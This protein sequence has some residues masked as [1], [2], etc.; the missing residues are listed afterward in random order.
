ML[1]SG[2][3]EFAWQAQKVVAGRS[4]CFAE[5]PGACMSRQIFRLNH[6]IQYDSEIAVYKTINERAFA[7]GLTPEDCKV[8]M[9]GAGTMNEMVTRA[10]R[11]IFNKANREEAKS[12]AG[13]DHQLSR[14]VVELSSTSS[15][16]NP[17]SI[18]TSSISKMGLGMPDWGQ[19]IQGNEQRYPVSY[20]RT[21]GHPQVA[22]PGYAMYYAWAIRHLDNQPFL[23][24]TFFNEYLWLNDTKSK[25]W[26]D[27]HN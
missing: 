3:V 4:S 14:E 22:A 7:P 21:V 24:P 25:F 12:S 11:T 8:E 9:L 20:Y 10:V 23:N 6:C 18:F 5:G 27:S 13:G 2:E 17:K 1:I 15:S 26:P 16:S 19:S